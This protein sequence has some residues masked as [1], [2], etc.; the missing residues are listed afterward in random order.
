MDQFK[1]KVQPSGEEFW[2]RKEK[3]L[4]QGMER[5][6]IGVEMLR[7]IPVGCR[8]G[9]CG[10]CRVRVLNGE[11]E[12]KKMSTKHVTEEQKR[13]GY[14]LAC[15]AYPRSEIELELATPEVG[16]SPRN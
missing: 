4:L 16:V 12:T 1:V 9:G 11:Y 2:C 8:G 6:R 14:V 3:H 13:A 5:L 7:S 15:R 10:I